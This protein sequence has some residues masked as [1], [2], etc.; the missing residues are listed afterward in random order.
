MTRSAA[1][2]LDRIRGLDL[3]RKV[4]IMNV[5]GGHEQSIAQQS[6]AARCPRG[7]S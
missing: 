2:W 4:R 7:W 6:C 3:P 5:C 1:D